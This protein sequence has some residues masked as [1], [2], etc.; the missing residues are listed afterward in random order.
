MISRAALLAL[1]PVVLACANP[2]TNSCA[3]YIAS[4]AATASPFC[5]TFTQSVVTATADLPAWASNCSSKPSHISKECSCY[6]TGGAGETTSTTAP[7]TTSAGTTLTTSTTSSATSA[8]ASSGGDCGAASVDELVGYASGTTG[9]GSGSGTTVTSCSGLESAIEGGGV[10]YIS[11][12]LD[13]CDVLDLESDTS[14]IGVGSSSGMING[15]FRIKKASNVIIRNL[16]MSYPPEGDDLISLTEATNVWID[17]CDLSTAG[18]TGSK[19]TYDGLLDITHASDYVTV[20][21]NK[22]HDHWKGSLVGHSDNNGDEDTGHLRV[23][24]HHNHFTNVNSRLPSIRFGTLH[25][26]SSCF[27]D[28]PTSGINV[29]MG[30]NALVESSY[31]SS[32]D[33]A[34]ITD[35]DSDE[36]GYAREEN[37]VF[38]DSPIEITQDTNYSP[39]Y[40]YTTDPASCICDWVKSNAGTGIVS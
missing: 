39:P 11:G 29:R 10:I 28:N 24:Y 19:D 5:A 20:S 22:F 25:T 1:V 18:L 17:H 23:T 7:T 36:D 2:D 26:Y 8:T 34:I 38:V 6:Y 15:G 32:T 14:V 16:V 33:K 4:N 35:L 37:N 13:G 9:G 30:A 27:E 12:V 31:F 21:W 3:S 40:S